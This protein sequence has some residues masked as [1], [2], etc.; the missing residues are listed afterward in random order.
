MTPRPDPR[1]GAERG[2]LA[3]SPRRSRMARNARGDSAALH[4]FFD[5]Y[6]RFISP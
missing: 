2:P 1:I 3:R 5:T 6:A 4:R